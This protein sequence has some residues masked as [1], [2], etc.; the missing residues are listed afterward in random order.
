MT[1]NCGVYVNGN[2]GMN[3]YNIKAIFVNIEDLILEV[4]F[5]KC[6]FWIY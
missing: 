1:L 5:V 2:Y 3:A 6:K 4:I